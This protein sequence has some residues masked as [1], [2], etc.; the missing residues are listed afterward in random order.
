ME[1]FIHIS[2]SEKVSDYPRKELLYYTPKTKISKIW[3][4]HKKTWR[5]ILHSPDMYLSK[6]L[7]EIFHYKNI[8]VD[9][10]LFYQLSVQSL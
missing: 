8:N 9:I 10:C 6:L 7:K 1:G 2:N 3:K 4:N 5:M